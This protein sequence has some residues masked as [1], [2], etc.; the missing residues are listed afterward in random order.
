MLAIQVNNLSITKTLR[1][2][3][4]I[5]VATG[6]TMPQNL[7]YSINGGAY[8]VSNSFVNLPLGKHRVTVKDLNN[9]NE[10]FR[11]FMLYILDNPSYNDSF[12]ISYSLD[13]EGWVSFHD[14]I[15]NYIFRTFTKLWSRAKLS[16]V[17]EQN[18]GRN[19][20]VK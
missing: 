8:Q 12:T 17:F 14:Y 9:G 5:A 19:I 13:K 10:A 16:M 20:I 6:F 4:G 7:N 3:G 18:V 11:E 15:P 1:R 2:Y